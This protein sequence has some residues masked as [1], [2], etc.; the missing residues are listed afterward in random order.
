[1]HRTTVR[2]SF[3]TRQ[4]RA[5]LWSQQDFARRSHSS[6]NQGI[7]THIYYSVFADDISTAARPR[8]FWYVLRVNATW[9]S[10]IRQCNLATDSDESRRAKR[11]SRV[12][13]TVVIFSL[14]KNSSVRWLTSHISGLACLMSCDTMCHPVQKGRRHH[15]SDLCSAFCLLFLV[16]SHN[17][18]QS[19]PFLS[20]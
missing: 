12:L 1:M 8:H 4:S 13:R 15:V 20:L 7:I 5:I 6:C 17:D 10:R 16:Y 2:P 3:S 14:S 11:W 19:N 18:L 9:H